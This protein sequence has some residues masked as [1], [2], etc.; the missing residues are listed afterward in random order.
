MS[1]MTGSV[2][3]LRYGIPN[4][5]LEKKVIDRRIALMEAEGVEFVANADVGEN[6][7]ADRPD[8]RL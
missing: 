2:V 5:K 1:G 7:K 8:E 4:M 6:V 3:L